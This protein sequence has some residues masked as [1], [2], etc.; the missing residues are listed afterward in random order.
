MTKAEMT[1]FEPM[2]APR[3]LNWRRSHASSRKY[4]HRAGSDFG[5][6]EDAIRCFGEMVEEQE[7]EAKT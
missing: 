6:I 5:H 2:P 7:D 3:P 1:I 4:D